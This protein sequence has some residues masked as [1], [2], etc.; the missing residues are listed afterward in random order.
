[1]IQVVF[2]NQDRAAMHMLEEVVTN[3]VGRAAKHTSVVVVTNLVRGAR[4][5]EETVIVERQMLTMKMAR[6][7]GR[8]KKKIHMVIVVIPMIPMKKRTE[9]MRLFLIHGIRTSRPE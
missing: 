4:Q 1:M 5:Q 3:I 6:C 7:R 8:W 2:M 9:M